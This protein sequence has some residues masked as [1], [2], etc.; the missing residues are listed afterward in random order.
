[1]LVALV[2]EDVRVDRAD[3]N[4]RAGAGE[5]PTTRA[6]SSPP[7]KSHSTWTATAGRDAGVGVDLGRRR[8]ACPRGRRAAASWRNF[9]NR[10]PVSAKPQD[11]ISISRVR[12]LA[13]AR[14]RRAGWISNRGAFPETSGMREDYRRRQRRGDGPQGRRPRMVRVGDRTAGPR[15]AVHRAASR[16]TRLRRLPTSHSLDCERLAL[17][18]AGVS[19]A[20]ASKAPISSRI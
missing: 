7:G 18:T 10:V 14:S 1:M 17:W 15:P 20:V 9:P 19:P 12:S 2:L 3:P 8:R 16:R 5:A 6:A 11:G 4:A 13:R